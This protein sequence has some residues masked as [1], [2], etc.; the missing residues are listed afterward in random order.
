MKKAKLLGYLSISHNLDANEDREHDN[1][2]TEYYF[3][4]KLDG[5]IYFFKAEYSYGSCF[6]GYTSASWGSLDNK[7]VKAKIVPVRLIVANKNIF[8]NVINGEVEKSIQ[9]SSDRYDAIIEEIKST[10]GEFIVSSSGDGG[11]QYYS[12]GIIEIN[13]ELFKN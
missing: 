13:E 4:I 7:L 5:E 2:G 12:S 6:S 3:Y 9:E 1:G 11:C 10:D 8:V